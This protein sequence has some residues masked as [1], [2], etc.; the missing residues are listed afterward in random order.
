MDFA[1]IERCWLQ[2]FVAFAKVLVFQMVKSRLCLLK[3]LLF[4][5]KSFQQSRIDIAIVII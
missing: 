5:R 4:S 3:S 1:T 2:N